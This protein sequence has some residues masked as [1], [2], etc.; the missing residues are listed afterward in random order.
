MILLKILFWIAI[1]FVV[2]NW[3]FRTFSKYILNSVMKML[4]NRAQED[5]KRQ[6][7]EYQRNYE[8]GDFRKSVYQ[9]DNVH[10]TAPKKEQKSK[11]AKIDDFAEDVEFEEL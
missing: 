2:V 6:S 5:L 7:N 9:D 4:V 3:F 11:N 10:V 1:F 8:A